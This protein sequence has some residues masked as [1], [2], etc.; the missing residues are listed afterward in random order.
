MGR[1]MG[2]VEKLTRIVVERAAAKEQDQSHGWELVERLRLQ[3]ENA[4]HT[5]S[6]ADKPVEAL[7]RRV[8]NLEQEL[9]G[10]KAAAA[11]WG[12]VPSS[13]PPKLPIQEAPELSRTKQVPFSL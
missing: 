11:H 13:S 2:K 6:E 5:I 3:L 1:G 8:I 10:Y 12:P 4:A 9:K 7:K